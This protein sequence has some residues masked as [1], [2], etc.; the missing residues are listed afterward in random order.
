MAIT[1]SRV[2][3]LLLNTFELTMVCVCRS[4]NWPLVPDIREDPAH[5]RL[6]DALLVICTTCQ[7]T[8]KKSYLWEKK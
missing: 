5:E 8:L 2:H 1:S 3:V 4:F 6:F 7:A